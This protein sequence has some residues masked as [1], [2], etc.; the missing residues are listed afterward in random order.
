[1]YEQMYKEEEDFSLFVTL[2]PDPAP[3]LS[4]RSKVEDSE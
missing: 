3:S 1:M 2:S 4:H